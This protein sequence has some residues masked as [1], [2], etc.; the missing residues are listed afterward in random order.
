M[1]VNIIGSMQVPIK[2]VC[3]LC[4]KELNHSAVPVENFHMAL[5][6]VIPCETCMTNT[7]RE[8]IDSAARN[9]KFKIDYMDKDE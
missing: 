8:I 7:A 6:K 9:I 2:T 1:I 5:V 3:S 4:G